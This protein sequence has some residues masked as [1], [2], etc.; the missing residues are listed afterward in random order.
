MLRYF[1]IH[2]IYHDTDILSTGVSL[3]NDEDNSSITKFKFPF[4]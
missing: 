2:A 1:P 4:Y 3:L